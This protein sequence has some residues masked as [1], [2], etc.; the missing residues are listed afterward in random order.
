MNKKSGDGYRCTQ[1]A[2]LLTK[3]AHWPPCNKHNAITL[4]HRAAPASDLTKP[5]V[6]ALSTTTPAREPGTRPDY[7]SR[8]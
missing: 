5:L 3:V 2:R 4:G 6:Q 1:H 8:T 7:H